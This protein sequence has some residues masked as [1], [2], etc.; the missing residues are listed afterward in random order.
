[1]SSS[2]LRYCL[3][4]ATCFT[5]NIAD[6]ILYNCQCANGYSDYMG[7]GQRCMDRSQLY[8]PFASTTYFWMFVFLGALAIIVLVAVWLA[9]SCRPRE[10]D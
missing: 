4:G 3:N 1:M 10:E 7:R 8:F 5:V 2:S 9:I 6:S